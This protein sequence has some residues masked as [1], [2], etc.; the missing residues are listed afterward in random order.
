MEEVRN[1]NSKVTKSSDKIAT[2][3]DFTQKRLR[4]VL[5]DSPVY[6]QKHTFG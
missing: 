5:A 4:I 2:S 1:I 3:Y 6:E